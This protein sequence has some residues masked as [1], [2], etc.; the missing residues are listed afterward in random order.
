MTFALPAEYSISLSYGFAFRVAWK[1]KSEEKGK[2][3]KWTNNWLKKETKEN[4]GQ[5]DDGNK[6]GSIRWRNI[7]HKFPLETKWISLV[8]LFAVSIPQH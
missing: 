7:K 1:K 5:V 2:E 3:I 4:S 6:N 8:L